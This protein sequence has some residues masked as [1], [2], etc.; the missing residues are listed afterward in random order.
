MSVRLLLT[1]KPLFLL[2]LWAEVAVP[3]WSYP[4]SPAEHQPYMSPSVVVYWLF[5]AR[6]ER[7]APYALAWFW[8]GGELALLD[9]TRDG[10]R[11][12]LVSKSLTFPPALT[13]AREK[14]E[15]MLMICPFKKQSHVKYAL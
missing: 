11:W 1:K 4:A 12:F 5:D 14:R 9:E 3:H 8:S 15:R 10:T 13:W 7:Y 2:L 6:A